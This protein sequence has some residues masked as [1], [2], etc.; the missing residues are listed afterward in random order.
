MK[1]VITFQCA[2]EYS[3]DNAQQNLLQN[4]NQNF[5]RIVQM[6]EDFFYIL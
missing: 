6:G 5:I 1:V 4:Q 2:L 3:N